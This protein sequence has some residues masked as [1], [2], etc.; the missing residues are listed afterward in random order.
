MIRKLT[1][2]MSHCENKMRKVKELAAQRTLA[3]LH[4]LIGINY[5]TTKLVSVMSQ[6]H[7]TQTQNWKVNRLDLI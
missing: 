2:T 3:F 7:G 5:A 6:A 4:R 1:R